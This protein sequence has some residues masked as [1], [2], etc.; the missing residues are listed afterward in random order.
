MIEINVDCLN[1]GCKIKYK[2][3]EL[4][5]NVEETLKTMTDEIIRVMNTRELEHNKKKHIDNLD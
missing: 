3:D 4:V 5:I 1:P 2:V